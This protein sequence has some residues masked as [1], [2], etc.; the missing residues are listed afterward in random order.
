MQAYIT[1]LIKNKILQPTICSLSW[2][3]TIYISI[4][5]TDVSFKSTG[6]L[7]LQSLVTVCDCL[8][9]EKANHWETKV[10]ACYTGSGIQ[11]SDGPSEVQDVNTG[12][13]RAVPGQVKPEE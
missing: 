1:C 6:Y 2:V 5:I 12:C 9:F 11:T 10:P 13:Q 8:P 3:H 7:F 4:Y